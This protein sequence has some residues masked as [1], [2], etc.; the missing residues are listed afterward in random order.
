[1]SA[2]WTPE[3]WRGR[4]LRQVPDYPDAAA[5]AGVES[6]LRAF[7]PL[8]FA[9]EARALKAALAKVADATF[10]AITVDGECSTNDCV[11]LLASGESDVEVTSS[12]ATRPASTSKGIPTASTPMPFTSPFIPSASG[13]PSR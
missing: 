4:A 10:N 7:P 5:L 8:V 1:M 3:T 9:G 13:R 2:K 12:S 6:K 11:F